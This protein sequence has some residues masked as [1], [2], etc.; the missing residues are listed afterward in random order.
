MFGRVPMVFSTSLQLKT[1]GR[2]SVWNPPWRTRAAP[3]G[4]AVQVQGRCYSS[5]THSVCEVSMRTT[6]RA[7][8]V[9][10]MLGVVMVLVYERS[11]AQ[12]RSNVPM[13]PNLFTV[14]HLPHNFHVI[15]PS[16]PDTSNVGGNVGV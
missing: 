13:P 12:M 14:K 4:E 5:R 2:F 11:S 15:M 7:V 16:G 1:A 6:L 3:R 8:W 10:F 9:V